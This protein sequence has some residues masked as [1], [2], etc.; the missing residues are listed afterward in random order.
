VKSISV[1]IALF[2][3]ACAAGASLKN[4]PALRDGA[5]PPLPAESSFETG[6][7]L[8][9]VVRAQGYAPNS[10]TVSAGGGQTAC[11]QYAGTPTIPESF[12][13]IFGSGPG[14]ADLTCCYRFTPS[15][16]LQGVAASVNQINGALIAA[17]AEDAK[18]GRKITCPPPLLEV[19]PDTVMHVDFSGSR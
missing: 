11:Y 8:K 1:V 3:G 2:L 13:R 16:V 6:T 9:D 14:E 15:G 10:S 5:A 19:K 17:A 4:G 18:A 7:T 12:I